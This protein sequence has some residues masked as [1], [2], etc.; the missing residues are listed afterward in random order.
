MKFGR[1]L[2]LSIYAIALIFVFFNVELQS[3]GLH[4]FRA[5]DKVT[6]RLYARGY[7]GVAL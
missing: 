6:L 3:G 4:C 2:P 5:S 7:N 1:L